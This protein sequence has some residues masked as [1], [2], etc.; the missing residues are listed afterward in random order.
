MVQK[1]VVELLDDID[2]TQATDTITFALDGISYAIDLSDTNKE[3][4]RDAFDLYLSAARKADTGFRSSRSRTTKSTSSRR[5]L[6]AIREWANASGHQ[7]STRGRIAATV[8]EAYE[9]AH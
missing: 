9:A 5:D 6:G 1:Y 3:K 2:G 8:I 4:L 7:V